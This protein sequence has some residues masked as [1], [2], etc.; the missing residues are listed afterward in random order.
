MVLSLRSPSDGLRPEL[1]VLGRRRDFGIDL[2]KLRDGRIAMIAAPGNFRGLGIES[3]IVWD[4]VC[5]G[6]GQ[7]LETVQSTSGRLVKKP[8]AHECRSVFIFVGQVPDLPSA[9]LTEPRPR[10]RSAPPLGC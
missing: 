4:P 6:S 9:G 10:E 3:M 2:I 1:Y 7:W 8:V 5:S